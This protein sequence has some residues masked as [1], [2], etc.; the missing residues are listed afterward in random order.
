M[1]R[2]PIELNGQMNRGRR[3]ASFEEQV[4]GNYSQIYYTS[5]IGSPVTPPYTV[6]LAIYLT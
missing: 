4:Y 6:H 1:S 3:S 5:I 2:N